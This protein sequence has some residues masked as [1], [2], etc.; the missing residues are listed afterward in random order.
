[1]TSSA[2]M[3][4]VRSL[5][6][7][8]DKVVYSLIGIL[9]ELIEEIAKH[10]L[11]VSIDE[12]ANKLYSFIGIFMLFKITFS[13]INYII[14][15]DTMLDKEKGGSKLIINIVITFALI[16][17]EPLGFKL[18]YEAQSAI[19]DENIVSRIILGTGG[20]S[21]NKLYISNFCE[22]EGFDMVTP[23]KVINRDPFQK[24]AST[25]EFIAMITLRPFVQV[26]ENAFENNK[27]S[28][29]KFIKQSG[30]CRAYNVENLLREDIVNFDDSD[31]KNP[32][33]LDYGLFISTIVG[34]IVCLI[35]AGF[36]LDA[37][38]R[39]IKL[40]FLQIIA[41]IPIMS[42][43]DPASS[44]KGLF[45]K[46][47]K[48]VG[49][50]WADLFLRLAAVYFAIF[51]I[52]NIQSISGDNFYVNLILILGAL[53]FAKKLPDILK[54]MFNIDLKG[55]FKLNPLKKFQEQAL[56]G[57]QIAGVATGLAGAA[58]GAKNILHGNSWH[59][60]FANAGKGIK[61]GFA[62]GYKNPATIKGLRS[63]TEFIRK[64]KA[65]QKEATRKA[66]KQLREF[67]IFNKEGQ[68][69]VEKAKTGEIKDGKHKID[70]TKNFK[71]QEY[72][73]SYK[74]V[75]NAKTE[76]SNA[77][78][79]AKDANSELSRIN[80]GNLTEDEKQQI[81][82]GTLTYE[83]LRQNASNQAY[84][85]DE[86]V[87]KKQNVL[88][89]LK[90][91]HKI[92]QDKYR[93]DAKNE[94]EMKEFMDRN[95]DYLNVS[96][97]NID[98]ATVNAERT[99]SSSPQAN[100]A[101][102]NANRN[103]YGSSEKHQQYSTMEEQ[104]K[105]L[106]EKRKQN[107]R[108]YSEAKD[109][110]TREELALKSSK[111]DEQLGELKVEREDFN[112]K[113]PEVA[114][115]YIQ[116]VVIPNKN[117]EIEELEKEREAL[118]NTFNTSEAAIK[119]YGR[120]YAANEDYQKAKHVCDIR[121]LQIKDAENTRNDLERRVRELRNKSQ[122]MREEQL[123]Q[124]AV[125]QNTNEVESNNSSSEQNIEQLFE[126]NTNN[127]QKDSSEEQKRNR[128]KYLQDEIAKWREAEDELRQY[129]GV[130]RYAQTEEYEKIQNKIRELEDE[131]YHL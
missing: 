130:P 106:E 24:K 23:S 12:I 81:K 6:A 84:A 44:K 112:N 129:Y 29:T 104:I 122:K 37:A 18:L 48:E 121:E 9:Y 110:K 38:L 52:S 86:K 66:K 109:E 74:K 33:F 63:G 39:T 93:D 82:N 90:E 26:D 75:E 53:M 79:V 97:A 10:E 123:K 2:G 120:D 69:L 125:Q 111:Y 35:F 108:E 70:Q 5:F 31:F 101:S 46:W 105:I 114:A 76:L 98:N 78:K 113:N 100:P 50:T 40:Y 92:I 89:G 91:R 87:S 103:Q 8:I 47:L 119:N 16:I 49:T 77:K 94:K 25:G 67:D 15:P 1:M 57:K 42:Y 96:N 11:T 131:L 32:Y 20:E 17:V 30:Y 88:D 3:D 99:Q 36:C 127:S 45:S 61:T 65:D 55:D 128:K 22:D 14:N 13:L 54:K 115:D 19:L 41:P 51:L 27:T 116:D 21:D 58:Y 43:M 56:G 71:H 83:G 126:S 124:E 102:Q 4:L 80:A 95:P 107:L 60:R 117:S 72:I 34:I 68:D 7:N 28:G 62:G 118:Y 85:A 64:E 73:D 59:E